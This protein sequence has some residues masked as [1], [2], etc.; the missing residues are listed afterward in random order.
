MDATD[1]ASQ[2]TPWQAARILHVSEGHPERF[3]VD[4]DHWRCVMAY[5][6]YWQQERIEQAEKCQHPGRKRAMLRQL[7]KNG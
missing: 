5:A 2:N 4:C 6:W 1:E 7:A 3:M